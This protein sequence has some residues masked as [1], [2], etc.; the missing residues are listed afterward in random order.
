MSHPWFD[1]FDWEALRKKTSKD[2]FF[3]PKEVNY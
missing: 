1:G 3:I 2:R